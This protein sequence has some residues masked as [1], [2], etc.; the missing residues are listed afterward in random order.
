M[1]KTKFYIKLPAILL[2][3][4]CQTCSMPKNNLSVNIYYIVTTMYP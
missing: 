2:V 1:L 3:G 4:L